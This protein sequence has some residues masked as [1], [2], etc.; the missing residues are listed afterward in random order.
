[1]YNSNILWH[2]FQF[3]AFMFIAAFLLFKVFENHLRVT[4]SMFWGLMTLYSLVVSV[5][6]ALALTEI[7]PFQS[8]SCL[9]INLIIVLSIVSIKVVI[10]ANIFS[11]LFV[12]FVLLNMQH[13]AI[14]LANATCAM[15]IL[16]Q[17]ASYP[18]G[19][20]LLI[21]VGYIIV[22]FPAEYFLLFKRYKRIVDE[23]IV[24]SHTKLLFCLPAGFY[25]A[26]SMLVNV[27]N[28]AD[29]SVNTE[30]L[31]PFI[32]ISFCAY[33]AYYA[34][35]NSILSGQDVA[36]S[37]ERAYAM[38]TQLAMWEKQYELLEIQRAKEARARHDWRQ[39]VVAIM[40]FVEN[41]DMSGLTGYLEDYGERV[42]VKEEPPVCDVTALNVLLLYYKRKAADLGIKMTVTTVEFKERKIEEQDLTVL[43]G[44]LL[45]N[46]LEACQH[47]TKGEKYIK[48]KVR[49]NGNRL[50]T[51][52][53]ENSFDGVVK[54][55]QDKI[56]SRKET[57]GIGLLSMENIAHKYDGDMK[58]K[59]EGNVFKVYIHF[60]G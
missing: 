16:P 2:F 32:L 19:D 39:H 27:N 20:M 56:I 22:M 31:L 48:L 46:A 10:S 35:I 4:K 47:Q 5:I 13:S 38:N 25:F 26:I 8:Y 14:L 55:S 51:I 41:K 28:T 37:H 59:A 49:N 53:C 52:L 60:L 44:N 42:L 6:I 34:A 57:G 18:Q 54:E 40:G 11:L 43:F 36:L 12:F 9:G 21:S 45:E 33:G 15:G 23:N 50:I 24:P 1:M 29:I 3:Y 7:S 17:L 30:A 58:A